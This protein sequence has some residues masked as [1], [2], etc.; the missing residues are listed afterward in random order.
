MNSTQEQQKTEQKNN[1]VKGSAKKKDGNFLYDFVKITGALP[2][3]AYLRTKVICVGDTK[4]SKLK[5]GMMISSNHISFAD[6]MILLTVFW[7]RRL[8]SLAT[9]DLFSTKLKRFFFT[10]MHCIE[11]NKENFTMH[12]FH[13]VRDALKADK[14]V[15]IFPEGQVNQTNEMLT[16]KSGAILMAH[17]S[18]KPILPVYIV[19]NDK[20]YHRQKVLVGDPINI[21]E[22]CG[23]I[24]SISD[25]KKASD[26][27]QKKEIE[28]M[29]YY[30]NLTDLKEKKQ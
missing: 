29:E 24:P 15:V 2:I 20:W 17:Q 13:A 3:L 16:F 25:L 21:R 1:N 11:V 27:L 7:N 18:D 22:I 9:Q 12:S 8:Y 30:S 14:A 5:G 23:S 10:R 6:P 26:L 19:K 4:P 28:L